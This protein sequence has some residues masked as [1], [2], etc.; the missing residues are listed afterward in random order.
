MGQAVAAPLGNCYYPSAPPNG[1]SRSD[2][3]E[4]A[5]LTR[6]EIQPLLSGL[7][8]FFAKTADRTGR[9]EAAE[10]ED[11]WQE[12]AEAKLGTLSKE[13]VHT[14]TSAVEN[15]F[16]AK[17]LQPASRVNYVDFM[18][19]MLDQ[20]GGYAEDGGVVARL[21]HAA[22]KD[23]QKFHE[24]VFEFARSTVD[25]TVVSEKNIDRCR[26]SLAQF[27][28]CLRDLLPQSSDPCSPT[29]DPDH[30]AQDLFTVL[31]IPEDGRLDLY[32]AL[33]YIL[34]RRKTPVELVLYDISY[35]ASRLF[36]QAIL[37]QKFEAIYHSSVLVFGTEFWYGGQVF[38]NEPP[39]DPKTFGP[40]LS[41]SLEELKPSVYNSSIRTVHLGSTLASLSELRQFLQLTMKAKYRP[42]N[43]DVLTH[44]CN[45]FSDDVVR[46]LTGKGIPETVSRLPE[47]V[48]STAGAKVLRPFL[49]KWL[50][51][52]E[53]ERP[54]VKDLSE[55]MREE[56]TKENESECIAWEEAVTGA[57]KD[58]TI[59]LGYFDP[60]ECTTLTRKQV[61][62]NSVMREENGR[63]IR[64]K[65][66]DEVMF[67]S[68]EDKSVRKEIRRSA[69][70]RLVDGRFVQ[71][72][73]V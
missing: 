4:R 64:P 71:A 43:Y 52:F 12:C 65:S 68:L 60:T 62:R 53:A 9:I 27:K 48:M 7:D 44:N 28:Q 32:N 47:L 17:L 33:A 38:E 70:R 46:F 1:T 13:Q 11:I 22:A 5:L 58:G 49:N 67:R 24:F 50:C 36:S 56:I 8:K 31:N 20:N 57:A 69:I 29:P 41:D 30:L 2:D 59:D 73:L 66:G 63:L 54:K 19:F 6:R 23:P 25:L 3:K 72:K 14:I 34:D 40:P 15:Y 42:D 37:G 55:E 16:E 21:R 61:K 26:I 39:I 18:S 45:S 10:L 35:G 51:G